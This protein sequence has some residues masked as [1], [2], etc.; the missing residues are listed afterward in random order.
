MGHVFI[1]KWSQ[2]AMR[3]SLTILCVCVCVC[4][5]V[6]RSRTS[7]RMWCPVFSRPTVRRFCWAGWETAPATTTTSTCST[8]PPAGQTAWPSTPSYTTSGDTH[9]HT[10][11]HTHV[12]AAVSALSRERLWS[13]L[14]GSEV[15]RVCVNKLWVDHV[16]SPRKHTHTHF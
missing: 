7:W 13:A 16:M 2:M 12:E 3:Y 15:K 10:H 14:I 4:V 6:R 8:S 5:C 11:T 1:F 9:T